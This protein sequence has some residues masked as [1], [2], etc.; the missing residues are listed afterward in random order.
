M[1]SSVAVSLSLFIAGKSLGILLMVLHFQKV[2]A[3]V[4]KEKFSGTLLA[5]GPSSSSRAKHLINW[6]EKTLTER[7]CA[8]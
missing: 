5:N 7:I 2:L 1:L 6:R 8:R 4:D 3:S